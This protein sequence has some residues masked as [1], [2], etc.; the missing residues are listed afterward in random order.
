LRG[1]GRAEEGWLASEA[2]GGLYVDWES[3]IPVLPFKGQR[4]PSQFQAVTA[5]ST[6]SPRPP[7]NA[8]S[9]QQLISKNYEIFEMEKQSIGR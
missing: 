5:S 6:W 1:N 4:S 3:F 9:Q 2:V 7:S 8:I